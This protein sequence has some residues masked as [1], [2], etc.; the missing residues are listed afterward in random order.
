[1]GLIASCQQ[2]IVSELL[3]L[4]AHS[5]AAVREVAPALSHCTAKAEIVQRAWQERDHR[6]FAGRCSGAGGCTAKR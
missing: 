6:L 3:C 1:M 2:A 4:L 5:L